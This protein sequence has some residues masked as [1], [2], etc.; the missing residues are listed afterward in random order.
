M[1]AGSRITLVAGTLAL[2]LH[3]GACI[4]DEQSLGSGAERDGKSE[5]GDIAGM[6]APPTGG[7]C[8]GIPACGFPCP[9]G[10][11][12]PKDQNG[13]EHTCTCVLAEYASQGPVPLRMYSSCGDPVCMGSRPHA[14]VPM[15]GTSDVEGATCNIEGARCDLRNDCNQELVCA[16]RD[17]KMQV[18]GCPISRR[19][20][21]TDIHYLDGEELARYQRE[22]LA[23]KLATWRYKGAPDRRRL[24]FIIDDTEASV[25]IEGSGDRVDLHGYISLA[26]A[27]LQRQAQQ[28]AALEREV[29][30]LKRAAAKERAPRAGSG[31]RRPRGRAGSGHPDLGVR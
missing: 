15:C 31:D 27:A 26:V 5:V 18:G 4:K 25:A 24:G 16:R 30:L 9:V 29:A 22:L 8:E 1:S 3:L 6:D 7:R 19:S 10:T 23:L 21:K 11:V 28:I 14:G 2:G 13:C 20:Y 12:N 17:P